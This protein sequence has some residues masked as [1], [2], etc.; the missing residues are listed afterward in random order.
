MMRR[1]EVVTEPTLREETGLESSSATI[2]YDTI[3]RFQESRLVF[4]TRFVRV[5]GAT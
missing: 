2:V 4:R 3:N 1:A 5:P